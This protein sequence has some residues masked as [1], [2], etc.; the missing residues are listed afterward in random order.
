MLLSACAS[1]STLTQANLKVDQNSLVQVAGKP[2]VELKAGESF[3]LNEYPVLVESAG[4]M[5]V[6]LVAP[7][8]AS[9]KE[10]IL[11]LRPQENFGGKSFD[12]KV[13][14]T[15]GEVVSGV[16][17][18]QI[19]LASKKVDQA[20]EK[21]NLLQQKFPE[22]TWLNFLRASCLVVKG[23][24]DEA[25][26]A[27]EVALKDFPEDPAGKRFYEALNGKAPAAKKGEQ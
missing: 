3:T 20:F 22:F 9:S 6:L 18:V 1:T 7:K 5:S 26:A 12:H 23:Q 25:K 15:V 16:N 17:E 21:L 2:P 24:R 27:L 8:D 10:L 13:N 4:Y 19:L 14:H 11:R